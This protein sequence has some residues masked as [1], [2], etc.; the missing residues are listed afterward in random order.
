MPALHHVGLINRHI[1][2]QI[3]K[4]QLV[5]RTIRNIARICLA[6][7]GIRHIMQNRTDREAQETIHLSHQICADFRE[8]VVDRNDMHAFAG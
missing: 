4:A 3:V 6:A 1:V 2:T 8:V 7:L 5:I